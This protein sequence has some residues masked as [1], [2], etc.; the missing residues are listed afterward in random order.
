MQVTVDTS[1]LMAV[2]LDEAGRER[3]IAATRGKSLIAPGSLP[4]EF[5][6]A[7]S[8]LAKRGLLNAER[9]SEAIVA[10]HRIPV[11]LKE[12][13]L[14]RALPLVIQARMYAYDAY[15]LQC[16]RQYDSPLL[17][18]DGAMQVHARELGIDLLDEEE[19]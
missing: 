9:I 19:S 7:L 5:G 4:W 12:V 13:E 14:E 15:M 10:F 16:A 17:T 2:V 6:N 11:Q 1:V 8:A 18:F 3:A